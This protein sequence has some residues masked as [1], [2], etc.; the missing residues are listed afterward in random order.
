MVPMLQC[1]D[2]STAATIHWWRH[3]MLAGLEHIS[4][5]LRSPTSQQPT[6]NLTMLAGATASTLMIAANFATN[7][8]LSQQQSA[9][10]ALGDNPGAGTGEQPVSMSAERLRVLGPHF[11]DIVLLLST[12]ACAL[13]QHGHLPALDVCAGTSSSSSGSSSGSSRHSSTRLSGSRTAAARAAAGGPSSSAQLD[14]AAA[15][16]LAQGQV[17]CVPATHKQLLELFGVSPQVA[18]WFAWLMIDCNLPLLEPGKC[19]LSNP[20][21]QAA[22]L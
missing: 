15:W 11:D 1:I 14:W 17:A 18:V 9:L 16:Q 22:Q 19:A 5:Q 12:Y 2:P 13:E 6:Q 20:H 4:A 10:G 3:L 21:V 8:G 7:Q